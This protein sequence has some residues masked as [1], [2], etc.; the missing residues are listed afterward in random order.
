MSLPG[1]F[2]ELAA[3]CLRSLPSRLPGKIRLARLVAQAAGND[4]A[5]ATLTGSGGV[6]YAVPSLNEPIALEI[7]AYG[8]YEGETIDAIVRHLPPQGVFVDVGANIGAISIPVARQ[9]P[10]AA[11]VAIEASPRMYGYLCRNIDVNGT[12]NIQAVHACAADED[13]ESVGFNEPPEA[14]FGMGSIFARFGH[15][16]TLVPQSRIDSVL[17]SLQTGSPHVL[18][19]DVEGAE[20]LALK[21]GRGCLS[22]SKQP[23]VVIFEF[24]DWAE[25]SLPD[26][27]PGA[28]Q[29]YLMDS[30]YALQLLEPHASQTTFPVTAGAAMIVAYRLPQ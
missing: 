24:C 18:K 10:D 6:T 28:A 4:T 14:K 5:P 23:P 22:N 20:L 13:C 11:I 17:R 7:I 19:I 8:R 26:Q 3:R 29:R 9:R 25:A 21:G 1:P 2:L 16:G 30:G 12:K 15:A 27:S